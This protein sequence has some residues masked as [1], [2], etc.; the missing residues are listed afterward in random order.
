MKPWSHFSALLI[1]L[2][3]LISLCVPTQGTAESPSPA[4]PSQQKKKAFDVRKV[5]T[6]RLPNGIPMHHWKLNN[7]LQVILLE[8]HEAPVLTFQ[9]WYPVGSADEK[10]DPRLMATG[11]A[12]LFEHMMF[13]GTQTVPDGQFDLRLTA[14]GM[15]DGNATTSADRTNYYQSVPI[16]AFE[17]VAQLEAD[18]MVHL[19]IDEKL[20]ETEKGAVLSERKKALE[21]PDR[22]ANQILYQTAFQVHPYRWSVLGTEAEIQGFSVAQAMHFYRTHYVPNRATLILAGDTTPL[23]AHPILDKYFGPLPE[24]ASLP[25]KF[26][27]REE[28]AQTKERTLTFTHPQISSGK[29]T[30]GYRAVAAK[31]EDLAALHVI[32]SLLTLGDSSI[33]QLKWVDGGLASA[34]GGS[35][36]EMKAPGLLTLSADLLIPSDPQNKN[37]SPE[38]VAQ[39]CLKVLDQELEKLRVQLPSK[40]LERAKN[41]LLLEFYSQWE[42]LPS[43]A[44]FIGEALIATQ[45]P[46]A[47]F[48]LT[49]RINSMSPQ[50][51]QAALKK[52]LIP[53]QR[54]VILGI[55]GK[56]LTGVIEKIPPE[57]APSPQSTPVQVNP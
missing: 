48:E 10:L 54:T 5:Q 3:L 53:S 29:L 37:S 57:A 24:A 16:E 21:N 12:H 2:G 43:L 7:G 1:Q 55:P 46:Q 20:L 47:G 42:T 9:V 32:N 45:R 11:L 15:Q 31:D 26:S 51:V 27:S 49:Q 25:P 34:I 6:Q 52:Y 41:R 19:K 35:L 8:R 36:D 56:T 38:K 22:V 13:R 40:L 30:L 18:R 14:A 4:L 44:N 28:P 33:L 17:L 39:E 50:K 23:A